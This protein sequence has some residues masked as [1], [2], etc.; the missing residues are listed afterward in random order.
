MGSE[1]PSRARQLVKTY[2]VLVSTVRPNLNAVAQISEELDGATASTGYCVLRPKNGSLD[3]RYLFHW[4]RTPTFVDSMILQATGASY[5]AVNDK[6][7]KSSKIPLPPLAEQ[8]RIAAILDKAD[9][10]RAKRRA[11]LAKLDTLLQSTFLTMFG[12]PVTNPMGWEVK[13]FNDVGTLERGKS[14][15]RPRNAP[16]LLGGPYPLIQTG[17]VANADGGYLT[18]YS[19]TYSELGLKQSRMW[20]S[21]V[22]CITIAANIANTAILTFDACF[23]DSI[24]G[25]IP[26]HLVRTEYVQYWLGFLRKIIEE[27]APQVAQKNINLK[28]LREL[29]IPIPPITLQDDFVQVVKNQIKL[30]NF[31]KK[32]MNQAN[33]LFH[34]LQQRA[35]KGE[36]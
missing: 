18:T 17:D 24:V 25:F 11:A 30:R 14:K 20:S 12:N 10:L 27:N 29:E 1:A 21:G 33:N 7:V 31:H 19:Q 35:F 26:N 4:V 28:I 3:S 16:E 6:I 9:A 23:P 2:D 15:H 22:L 8:R 34:A 32:H 13:Q 36:L 5:P